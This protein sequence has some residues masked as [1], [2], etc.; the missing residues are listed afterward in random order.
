MET[1]ITDNIAHFGYLAI[2]FLMALENVFPPIP[3]EL[4]LTFAG[5]AT[6]HS[7]LTL[8]GVVIAATLG[9]TLGALI[10][11]GVGRLLTPERLAW[12]VN[13]WVGRVLRFK[14]A[15]L[16][17]T[18][19]W[20]QGNGGWAVLICRCVPVVRSLI[21]I[22]AGMSRMRLPQFTLLTVIGTLVWNIALVALGRGAGNTWPHV[23]AMVD[24]YAWLTVILLGILGSLGLVLWRHHHPVRAKEQL[25]E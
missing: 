12:L 13:G 10:L 6:L 2:F 23:V 3:S 17:K 5:F 1:L 9:A 14:M 24:Q 20:F 15:D 19:R 7:S 21:S 4:V 25:K 18:T 22:P 8:M 16:N 11:Y